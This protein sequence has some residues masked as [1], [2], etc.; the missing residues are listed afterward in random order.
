MDGRGLAE[1]VRASVH[2]YNTTAELER[3]CEIIT[4]IKDTI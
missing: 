1:L 3:L 2:Y 4:S